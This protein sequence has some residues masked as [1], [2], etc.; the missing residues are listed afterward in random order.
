M[1]GLDDEEPR[2]MR[3]ASDGDATQPLDDECLRR[4][5]DAWTGSVPLDRVMMFYWILC[6]FFRQRARK[7]RNSVRVPV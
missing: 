7:M 3:S 5:I 2:A 1:W 4:R 6:S